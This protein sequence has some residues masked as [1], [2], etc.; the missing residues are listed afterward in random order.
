MIL[1]QDGERLDVVL[2]AG[3]AARTVLL[4]VPDIP[5]AMA[6]LRYNVCAQRRSLRPSRGRRASIRRPSGTHWEPSRPLSP[7][8]PVDT[9]SSTD[10]RSRFSF[11]YA[12]NPAGA[13]ELSRVVAELPVTGRRIVCNTHVGNRHP[14]HLEL[15]VPVLADAFDVFVLSCS[16][17]ELCP[18]YARLA[19]P[20]R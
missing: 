17:E 5:A 1:A 14:S 10:S 7:T 3:C 8:I 18:E 4:A 19:A 11:D 16:P 2:A 9:T 12:H 15:V 13:A 20:T 6:G